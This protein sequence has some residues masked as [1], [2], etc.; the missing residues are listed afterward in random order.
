MLASN[1][2]STLYLTKLEKEIRILKRTKIITVSIVALFL[3]V[4]FVM[5]QLGCS[6]I[7]Q[8][9]TTENEPVQNETR[10]MSV[11]L[12]ANNTPVSNG[13]YYNASYISFKA[14]GGFLTTSCFVKKDNGEFISYANGSL[15]ASEGQYTFVAVDFFG[16]TPF[17]TITL[18]RTKP[19]GVLYAGNNE[20]YHK[21]ITNA[22]FV[23]YKVT[24]NYA[25]AT[26]YVQPPKSIT[27][28]TMTSGY[29]WTTDGAYTFYAVDRAGNTAS[30]M[31]IVLDK[32]PPVGQ[33]IS[34]STSIPSGSTTDSDF[35]YYAN[36]ATTG[37]SKL[38]LIRPNGKI[39]NYVENTII[40]STS[41]NGQY[42]FRA[43]DRVGN[44]SEKS[45]YLETQNPI[46]YL[47]ADDV[48]VGNNTYT[49]ASRISMSAS[50]VSNLQCF[51]KLPDTDTFVPYSQFVSLYLIG[52]YEFYAQ[53]ES[54]NKSSVVWIV[55]DRENKEVEI[56]GVVDNVAN[57]EVS[58]HWDEYDNNTRANIVS[59]TVNGKDYYH[60]T[61]TENN[62]DDNNPTIQTINNGI[63]NIESI[64]QAGNIWSTQFISHHQDMLSSTVNTEFYETYDNTNNY[65]SFES[66]PN[67]TTFATSREN[68]LVKIGNW[69]SGSW[70]GGIP[71][72][73]ID[74]ENAQYGQYYIYK[75]SNN[76][77]EVVAYFTKDRL[78]SVISQYAVQSIKSYYFWQKEL[79]PIYENNDLFALSK[80]SIFIG[81]QVELSPNIHYLVD[82]Q[83]L[84]NNY[85]TKDNIIYNKSGL[86]TLMV[87]DDY[88]NSYDYELR[89]VDTP[90]DIYYKLKDGDYNRT[91]D[92]IN[93][94]LDN[95]VTLKTY[96]T[97]SLD[98]AMLIVKDQS[99]NQLAILQNDQEYTVTQS[100]KYIVQS[101]NLYGYSQEIIFEINID[102]TITESIPPSA[103]L[104]GVS[105]NG[106]TSGTVTLINPSKPVTITAYKDDIQFEYTFGQVLSEVGK[107]TITL[108]DIDGNSITYSF[109]IVYEVNFAGYIIIILVILAI[110]SIIIVVLRKKALRRKVNKN[111]HRKAIN[112]T[113][114]KK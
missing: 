9:N 109:E 79:S 104:K 57:G 106:K 36:D 38:E 98:Y 17:Y 89:I 61:N 1:I 83:T 39:E 62:N 22:S 15:I 13:G 6:Y 49:N 25:L 82:G 16:Q 85:P 60:S 68:S 69:T 24:D 18:D 65:Y 63:Y 37:I 103:E 72:D 27:Y 8:P 101:V 111:N 26:I 80:Q 77:N 58:L 84:D 32:T 110:V 81:T 102:D 64:D 76:P 113:Q 78:D 44:V 67:A 20:T 23:T 108:T 3:C 10:A 105:N 74:K 34:N 42:I 70:D 93:Y 29:Q 53:D 4:V 112:N 55:V 46:S 86:H 107:Y 31:S 30:A 19:Q 92:G 45:V 5:G 12:Y 47:Y 91:I 59:I 51:V 54:Q 11:Q 87:Y 96:D 100:G 94:I 14:I 88:S 71:I 35:I 48:L 43:T 50:G 21:A 97:L 56:D 73:E 99:G 95:E 2:A 90:S 28:T 33:I 41:V 66:L 40:P 7:E 52:R 114:Q 75:S